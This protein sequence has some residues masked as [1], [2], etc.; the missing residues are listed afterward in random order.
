[1]TIYRVKS[2]ILIA[3]FWQPAV[4]VWL[5][6]ALVSSPLATLSQTRIACTDVF[7]R[8]AN[9]TNQQLYLHPAPDGIDASYAWTFPGGRG[10]G[11]RVIDA[12]Y[13]WNLN[14]EDLPAPF[15]QNG[16][17]GADH[18][19]GTV[20][21]I[22]ACDNGYG[23]TG[24]ANRARFGYSTASKRADDSFNY[25]TSIRDATRQLSAGDVIFLPSQT[26]TGLALN[27]P[28]SN[29]CGLGDEDGAAERDKVPVEW[30][31]DVFAAIAEA[32]AKGIVVVE[33]AGNRG[34]NLDDAR[35]QGK[36]DRRVRDSGAILVGAG[37]SAAAAPTKTN[38]GGI[39]WTPQAPLPFSDYGSRVDVQ[40]WGERV[41]TTGQGGPST[42]GPDP[43]DK[44]QM[45]CNF[46]GTSSATPMVAGVVAS[47]QGMLKALGRPPLLPTEMRDLLV[48]TGTPQQ[49]ADLDGDG[50]IDPRHLGPLPN[51]RAAI[52]ALLKTSMA[53]GHFNDDAWE[54]LAIGVPYA[55]VNGVKGAGKV[56]V[57]MGSANGLEVHSPITFSQETPDVTSAAEKGDHF[58]F[59]L[60]VGDF[61][62]NGRDDLAIGVPFEDVDGNIVDAGAVNILYSDNRGLNPSLRPE[63]P[64][65]I[66]QNSNA[67]PNYARAGD[68]FGYSLTAGDFDGN[69]RDDLAIGVPGETVALPGKDAQNAGSVN[70]I[71]SDATG[72]NPSFRTQ[73]FDQ[74]HPT[75]VRGAV[76]AGDRFGY[77]LAAGDFDG[78]GRDDLAVGVPYEMVEGN[79][80]AGVVNVIYSR[81]GGLDGTFKPGLLHQNVPYIPSEAE[82]GD[83]FGYALAVGD[84]DNNGD[85]DLAVGV[86]GEDVFDK[87]DAGVVNVI[88]G[89]ATGLTASFRVQEFHQ[90]SPNLPEEAE[91]GDR[92]GAALA[93]G[94][95]DNSRPNYT[96]DDL[97]IGAPGEDVSRWVGGV[98]QSFRD[99]GAVTV[100]YGQGIGGLNPAYR[101]H[102]FQ[103]NEPTGLFLG[104]AGEHFGATLAAGRFNDSGPTQ[105]ED[106]AIGVLARYSGW[107]G[108]LR[109]GFTYSLYGQGLAGLS[110][111]G[112]TA[113]TGF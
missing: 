106:L 37:Q 56:V 63:S 102:L 32:T 89:D 18:E 103:Q 35:Y 98:L 36:F 29:L 96:R 80:Q 97:A 52:N 54:D 15:Y 86:P 47:I 92:F 53:T 79:P 5:V 73:E 12:V 105:T 66:H 14:H 65:F 59:A 68:Q 49:Q 34:R 70:V 8:T 87:T 19:T 90:N 24:I 1:M 27:S 42:T 23:V 77:A 95:F 72:L 11:V 40:G 74:D 7:P 28:A 41:F 111:E 69:G 31:D 61:D 84:F 4:T 2:K 71:Y 21:I 48:A 16:N 45:Y 58:G 30:Q 94:D 17:A 67:M 112:L 110:T 64:R 9:Y 85:Q 55:E 91:N 88:Y 50:T 10:D 6:V 76:E 81:T 46:A 25:S 75:E 78:N 13:G 82:P 20:G 104:Q 43:T 39:A 108:S 113:Y 101:A 22:A 109:R 44:N 51:L 38:C 100:I 62:G 107:D 33:A 57:L 83:L 93:T 60:A 26:S 3:K 99:A